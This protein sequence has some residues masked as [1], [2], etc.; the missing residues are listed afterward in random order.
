MPEIV[1]K[2]VSHKGKT[3]SWN[4]R[5]VTLCG[6]RFDSG[7]FGEPFIYGPATCLECKKAKAEGKTTSAL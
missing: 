1:S 2:G 4:G 6:Q 5:A 7:S 3:S